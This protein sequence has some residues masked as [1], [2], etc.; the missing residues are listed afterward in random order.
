MISSSIPDGRCIQSTASNILVVPRARLSPVQHRNIAIATVGP[1]SQ[2]QPFCALLTYH[3][4][5]SILWG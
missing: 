4:G 2:M 3:S 5:T 1:A